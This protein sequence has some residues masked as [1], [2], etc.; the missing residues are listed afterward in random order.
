LAGKVEQD[1]LLKALDDST[2]TVLK[3]A[4][5]KAKERIDGLQLGDQ[6]AELRSDV[7]ILTCLRLESR[8]G[9]RWTDGRTDG[10]DD[11]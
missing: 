5:A 6:L 7:R 2:K 3:H 1:T 11:E 4:E 8:S 10:L 9:E